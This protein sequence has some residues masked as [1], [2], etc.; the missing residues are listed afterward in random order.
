MF[1]R[2]SDRAR[3]IVVLAQGEARQ[4][5][6]DEVGTEHLVLA[7]MA[8]RNGVAALTLRTLGATPEEGRRLVEALRPRGRTSER[9]QVPLTAAARRVLGDA[10]AQA[11]S[12]GRRLVDTTQL[13]LAIL[14]AADS[15]GLRLV[16]QLGV[17]PDEMRARLEAEPAPPHEDGDRATVSRTIGRAL[18]PPA[19]PPLEWEMGLPDPE[20]EELHPDLLEALL[21]A[22]AEAYALGERA[23]APE[24]L[25]VGLLALHGEPAATA[26]REAGVTLEAVH[27]QLQLSALADVAVPDVPRLGRALSHF[28]SA[29][30]GERRAS[31]GAITTLEMLAILITHAPGVRLLLRA[32]GGDPD[33][34]RRRLAK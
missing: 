24:H 32:A 12:Q 20:L 31:P 11:E 3:R 13:L 16:R 17:D 7:L 15:T 18:P 1:Q 30:R 2:F 4:L 26:I 25:I 23:V 14:A 29:S 27:D 6:H 5:A 22:R 8:D 19:G 34:L 33:A 21:F 28:L 10:V 9:G